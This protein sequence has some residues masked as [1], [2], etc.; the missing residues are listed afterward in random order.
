[1]AGAGGDDVEDFGGPGSADA[2]VC[3]LRDHLGQSLVGS[4]PL[5][6]WFFFN[7]WKIKR[8]SLGKAGKDNEEQREKEAL[9]LLVM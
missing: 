6:R 9:E 7:S 2:E 1:M 3:L 5:L 4:G 8:N